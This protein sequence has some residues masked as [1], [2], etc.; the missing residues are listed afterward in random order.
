MNIHIIHASHN[1]KAVVQIEIYEYIEYWAI[2]NRLA[3]R[4]PTEMFYY[5]HYYLVNKPNDDDDDDRKQN[6]SRNF[7]KI[8]IIWW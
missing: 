6:S 5:Y 1:Q 2:C 8:W 3:R 4:E 7:V